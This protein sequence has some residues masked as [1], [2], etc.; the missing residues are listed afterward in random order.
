MANKYFRF[1]LFTLLIT[2]YLVGCRTASPPSEAP[3]KETLNSHHD[4]NSQKISQATLKSV[5][6]D[7][8]AIDR[9]ANPCEN[10]YQFA[11]GKWLTRT[12]IPEDKPRWS[13]SFDEI[14]ERNLNDLRRILEEMANEK[15]KT[16]EPGKL[17]AF[18]QSC[19][20]EKRVEKEGIAPL[21]ELFQRVD[22]VKNPQDLFKVLADLHRHKVWAFFDID[23]EQDFK[24]ATQMISY[25]D[26]SGL[27]LPDRNYYLEQNKR[28]KKL[29]SRYLK[30]VA[31]MLELIG[32]PKDRS[33]RAAKSIMALE[34]EI[35]KVSKTRVERRDLKKMYN[36]VERKGLAK[37]AKRIRWNIYFKAL[38]F[39]DLTAISVTSPK[40]FKA[41]DRLVAKTPRPILKDYLKWHI[42]HN[43]APTL[44]KAIVDEDFSMNQAFTGQ[45]VQKSRWKRC[46]A[47][48]DE[49]LGELLAKPY[50]KLRFSGNS[51]AAAEQMVQA[52]AKSFGNILKKLDWMDAKTKEFALKKLSTIS[53]MIGFPA[54]WKKYP[55]DITESYTRNM[56]AAMAYDLKYTLEKIGKPVDRTEWSMTP[57]TTNAYYNPLKNQMVFPAGILQP[58][59]YSAEANFAVNLGAIG[60]VIGHELTHGFDDQGA[61]FDEKGNMKNWWTADVEKRFKQKNECVVKQY[62]KYE[63]LPGV[64]LNGK[65]TLGEN[66]ADMGGIKISYQAYQILAQ[67]NSNSKLQVEGFSEDQLFFLAVGQAWCSKYRDDFARLRAKTDVHSHPIYRVNGSLSN[68][69][70]FAEAFSCKQHSAMNPA[71]RCEVW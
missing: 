2:I 29:R 67:E 46:V 65:L 31:K 47:A 70:A 28:S 32:Y 40:Y 45:K 51:K 3:P 68:L 30:H 66:I 6:L 11:C 55:F 9:S 21:H 61:L 33:E 49:A 64:K 71:K 43:Y 53:F 18:Y 16:S 60:Y 50:I 17:G 36:R 10:F 59:F 19:M 20:D 37:L 7:G 35:A 1:L 14:H 42:V 5:G 34:T 26:Q 39:P 44:T 8:T 56:M 15:K 25:L 12:Q 63:V 22:K 69:P 48:A 13:R 58:P 41:I 24:D 57:Q 4:P 23:A 38:G 62:D 52:I 27:G 54:N